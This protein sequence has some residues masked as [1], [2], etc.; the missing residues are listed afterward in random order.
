MI[1]DSIPT[2][3]RLPTIETHPKNVNIMKAPPGRQPLKKGEKAEG[4]V[5][6]RAVAAAVAARKDAATIEKTTVISKVKEWFASRGNIGPASNS[7][8]SGTTA[9]AAAVETARISK[10]IAAQLRSFSGTPRLS[11]RP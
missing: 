10:R 6:D 9:T 3:R 1:S 4:P 5:K 2:P 8:I 11:N 7:I